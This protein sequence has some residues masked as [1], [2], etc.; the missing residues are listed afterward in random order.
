MVASPSINLEQAVGK[1]V[2]YIINDPELSKV[3]FQGIATKHWDGFVCIEELIK[4][5]P[6][7]EYHGKIQIYHQVQFTNFEILGK[8][9]EEQRDARAEHQTLYREAVKRLCP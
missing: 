1:V 3:L 8:T 7:I 4:R 6:Q 2:Q 5:N 9:E